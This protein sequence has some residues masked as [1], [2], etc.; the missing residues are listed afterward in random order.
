MLV[1]TFWLPQVFTLDYVHNIK[2]SNI[3]LYFWYQRK[4]KIYSM[5]SYPTTGY[6][7]TISITKASDLY[8]IRWWLNARHVLHM[9]FLNVLNGM[10]M[11][12][13]CSVYALSRKYM[14]FINGRFLTFSWTF[15]WTN[16]SNVIT[17][18]IIPWLPRIM[19]CCIYMIITWVVLPLKN[20]WA[21]LFSIGRFF[22]Q[23]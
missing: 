14:V 9:V 2:M 5:L 1:R 13:S 20:R 17:F 22:F 18:L 23:Q 16:V 6:L 4:K 19:H 3:H 21:S 10:Y 15:S 12:L 7:T 8:Y 11:L